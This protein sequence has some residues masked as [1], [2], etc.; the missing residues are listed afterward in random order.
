MGLRDDLKAKARWLYG[1]DTPAMVA[2]AFLSDATLAL[3]L[4]RGMSF[5]N[6]FTLTKPFAFILHKLNAVLCGC[7]IGVN[8]RFGKR[9]IILHSV[10]ITINSAMVAGDDVTLESGV[11]I[12]A[13]KGKSPRIGDRVFFGSG[14]KVVGDI[15]I[16]N[17][18]LVGANAVVVKSVPASVVVGGVPAKVIR[19]IGVPT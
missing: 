5:L 13:E 1:A 11:V 7:V 12:G 2:R 18:V 4:Y 8:A 14:A 19:E 10:G 15:S 17:D 3:L 16:G 6:K 9:M